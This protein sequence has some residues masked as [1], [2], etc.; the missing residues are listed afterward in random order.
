MSAVDFRSEVP[1]V[2][3]SLINSEF[4]RRLQEQRVLHK[5]EV[6]FHLAEIDKH[7]AAE[8]ALESMIQ[9]AEKIIAIM[10][11]VPAKDAEAP[12]EAPAEDVGD[13]PGWTEATMAVVGKPAEPLVHNEPPAPHGQEAL[14]SHRA[15]SGGNLWRARLLRSHG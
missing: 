10:L 13:L 9:A 2:D 7:G 4:I 5:R 15:E 1:P 14:M 8:E 12:D 11:P 3:S 6:A